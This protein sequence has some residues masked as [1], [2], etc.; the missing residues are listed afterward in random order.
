MQVEITFCFVLRIGR[1]FFYW[2]FKR[3]DA[4]NYLFLFYECAVFKFMNM[5]KNLYVQNAANYKQS[6]KINQDR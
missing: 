4:Q 2:D 1:T 3:I 6:S 5:H